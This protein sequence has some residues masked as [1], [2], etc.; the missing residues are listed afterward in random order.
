MGDVLRPDTEGA[1]EGKAGAIVLLLTP[2]QLDPTLPTELVIERDERGWVKWRAPLTAPRLRWSSPARKPKRGVTPG[3]CKVRDGIVAK[4][5]ASVLR[6][7]KSCERVMDVLEAAGGSMTLDALADALQVK[8]PRDLTRRKNIETGKGRDGFVTRLENVG[9]LEVFGDTVVLAENW[10][11]ALDR[12]RDRAGEIEL[13]RRDMARYNRERDGYRNRNKIKPDTA[14]TQEAMKE[15]RESYPGRRRRDITAALAL[16]FAERPE[17]RGRRAGQIACM[18]PWYLPEDFP[19]GPSGVPK[20]A[21]V[22]AI[23][24]GEAVA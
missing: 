7:G 5:R 12:E 2:A 14:P 13:Y 10:L 8:R 11:E 20:D 17:Y 24:D 9:V 15:S 22:D 18:L 16:L 1:Q 19:R 21:E 23:L 6:L 3:T 4:K